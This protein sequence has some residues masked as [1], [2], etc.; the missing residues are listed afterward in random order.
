MQSQEALRS[1]TPVTVN[2]ADDFAYDRGDIP[3]FNF[4]EADRVLIATL[5]ELIEALRWLLITFSNN[6]RLSI[7]SND[8]IYVN[9]HILYLFSKLKGE[10]KVQRE[11]TRTLRKALILVVLYG[12]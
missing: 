9:Y 3:I 12:A 10:V 2:N 8:I 1:R 5:Q 4:D 7:L 6:W 11:E